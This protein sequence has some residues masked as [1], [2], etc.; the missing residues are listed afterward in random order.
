MTRHIGNNASP[1]QKP[2]TTAAHK[3]PTTRPTGA[4]I[5][6]Q[7][8]RTPQGVSAAAPSAVPAGSAAQK[9]MP[10]KPKPAL[11]GA[12]G[13]LDKPKAAPRAQ[14]KVSNPDA[15]QVT[16]PFGFAAVD[17]PNGQASAVA[18][19]GSGSHADHMSLQVVAA[20]LRNILVFEEPADISKRLLMS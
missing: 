6:V 4:S 3:P 18:H 17:R 10:A 13:A 7:P 12:A 15:A 1:L 8:P 9:G 20:P 5:A 2:K 14:R 19:C 16:R 11:E